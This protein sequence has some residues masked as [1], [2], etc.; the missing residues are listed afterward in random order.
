MK[1]QA[2]EIDDQVLFAVVDVIH[3]DRFE[4]VRVR[5][6]ETPDRQQHQDPV[7]SLFRDLNVHGWIHFL[8]GLDAAAVIPKSA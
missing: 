6:V 5:A 3:G 2:A 4:C 1:F 7:F 8:L